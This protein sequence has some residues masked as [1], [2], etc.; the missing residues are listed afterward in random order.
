MHQ[1]FQLATPSMDS[2]ASTLVGKYLGDPNSPILMREVAYILMMEEAD[3]AALDMGRLMR[4]SDRRELYHTRIW[5][6]SLPKT[7]V[8]AI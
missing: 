4:L 1:Y 7:L 6:V 3:K 5:W 8:C 2:V